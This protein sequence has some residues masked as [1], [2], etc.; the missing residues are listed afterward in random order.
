MSG[1]CPSRVLPIKKAANELSF[2]P[3]G[4]PQGV[5]EGD[6]PGAVGPALRLQPGAG[7]RHRQETRGHF[8]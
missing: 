5:P 7:G 8:R 4:A 1:H 6:D 3:V 2:P